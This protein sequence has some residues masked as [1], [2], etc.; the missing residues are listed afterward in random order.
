MGHVTL[1]RGDKRRGESP[2]PEKYRTN[3]LMTRQM[4]GGDPA[5]ISKH[6]LFEAVRSHVMPNL[7]SEKHFL[8]KSSFLSFS[9]DRRRAEYYAADGDPASLIPSAEYAE[10]RY[11]FTLT[12]SNAHMTSDGVYSLR[13]KCDYNLHRPDVQGCIAQVVA[14]VTSCPS[15]PPDGTQNH[16]LVLIDVASYLEKHSTYA[17]CGGALDLARRDSEWLVL[18]VDYVPEIPGLASRVPLSPIWN[19]QHYRLASE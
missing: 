15:C 2:W 9:A 10:T 3:G 8:E 5:Y 4:D 19:A 11:I 18:P 6:G 13:Y 1:Y 14:F 16:H 12:A 17:L 7:E